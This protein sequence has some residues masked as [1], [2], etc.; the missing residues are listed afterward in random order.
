MNTGANGMTMV[1]HKP[2]T[3]EHTITFGSMWCRVPSF[4][5]DT[6]YF[7][8]FNQEKIIFNTKWMRNSLIWL[9][10]KL[11]LVDSGSS[12]YPLTLLEMHSYINPVK[13]IPDSRETQELHRMWSYLAA[14]PKTMTSIS[15]IFLYDH[16]G[17]VSNFDLKRPNIRK[18]KLFLWHRV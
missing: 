11:Q 18:W 3:Q 17:I 2:L 4:F 15:P 1:T 7:S 14:L 9:L 8:I 5:S 13:C 12:A 16:A 6:R 10:S